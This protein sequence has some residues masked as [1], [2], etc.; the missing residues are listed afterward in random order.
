[1]QRN[2]KTAHRKQRNKF[3]ETI[4]EA[5]QIVNSLDEDFKIAVLNI[6]KE[7]KNK[8]DK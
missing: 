7:L 8:M 5:V 4:P 3:P 6:S 1:M 2:K